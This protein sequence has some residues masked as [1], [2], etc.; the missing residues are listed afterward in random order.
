MAAVGGARCLAQ[1][2][3]STKRFKEAIGRRVRYWRQPGLLSHSYHDPTA[4]PWTDGPLD[5]ILVWRRVS[6]RQPFL[7]TIR[8]FVS[9]S[10]L[11]PTCHSFAGTHLLIRSLSVQ[12][13][14]CWPVCLVHPTACAA[15]VNL[16]RDI[17]SGWPCYCWASYLDLQPVSSTS[18]WLATWSWKPRQCYPYYLSF[19][20]ATIR[21]LI[22]YT[23]W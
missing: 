5:S 10:F 9:S 21:W 23:G 17:R 3:A 16:T 11:R 18:C 14:S 1:H 4:L 19:T 22:A 12:F 13:A 20:S 15:V 7:A 2:W 8:A 6:A